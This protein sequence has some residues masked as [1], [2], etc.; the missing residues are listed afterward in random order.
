M[1]FSSQSDDAED[2]MNEEEIR[3]LVKTAQS[4][5]N[6]GFTA[7]EVEIIK[8]KV[9]ANTENLMAVTKS[10]ELSAMLTGDADIEVAEQA[11]EVDRIAN[12]CRDVLTGDI[13]N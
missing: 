2:E 8:V 9:Q 3:A 12:V 7:L 4:I 13:I 5:E 11:A 6:V 1:T 10:K